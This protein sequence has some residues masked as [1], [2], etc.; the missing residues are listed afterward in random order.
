MKRT[1]QICISGLLCAVILLGAG[2]GTSKRIPYAEHLGSAY[3][4]LTGDFRF[5]AKV[6]HTLALNSQDFQNLDINLGSCKIQIVPGSEYLLEWWGS[7]EFLNAEV[8]ENTLYLSDT[9]TS[10]DY[11]EENAPYLPDTSSYYGEIILTMPEDVLFD[12]ITLRGATAQIDCSLPI[13]CQQLSVNL[14][15]SSLIVNDLHCETMSANVDS[16]SYY[17]VDNLNAGTCQVDIEI[18]AVELYGAIRK[19]SQVHCAMGDASL[20]LSEDAQLGTMNLVSNSHGSVSVNDVMTDDASSTSIGTG[21]A[22]LNVNCTAGSV[23]VY[24]PDYY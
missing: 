20:Y 15:S 10:S 12:T 6:H 19:D 5:D 3:T 8:T 18:G 23:N 7:S 9:R 13:E 22:V 2:I 11:L 24:T 16:G 17:I 4:Q 21:N 14:E 1:L